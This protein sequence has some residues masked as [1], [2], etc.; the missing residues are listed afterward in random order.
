MF[1]PQAHGLDWMRGI[2]RATPIVTLAAALTGA[3]CAF[4]TDKS[5]KVFVTLE[6]PSHVVLRGQEMS[7]YAQAWQVS[8]SDTG[9]ITN[10]DFAFI[11]GSGLAARGG[12][13]WRDRGG[14]GV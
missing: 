11:S 13:G 2:V 6:A 4:P 1:G 8:G 10:V 14:G 5:D 3:G 12:K 9:P 7:V